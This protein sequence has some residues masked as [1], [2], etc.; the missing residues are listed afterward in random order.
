[1]SGCFSATGS[2]NQCGSQFGQPRLNKADGG[3]GIKAGGIPTRCDDSDKRAIKHQVGAITN[4]SAANRQQANKRPRWVAI[5]ILHCLAPGKLPASRRRFDSAK[6]SLAV[7]GLIVSFS[8]CSHRG[9][10]AS[11]RSVSRAP[12]LQT[13]IIDSRL[14]RPGRLCHGNLETN[15]P[16]IARTGDHTFNTGKRKTPDVHE[17]E[18]AEIAQDHSI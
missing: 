12:S 14:A 10:P 18:V 17:D 8:S 6:R 3:R 7:T 1:M 16:G 13:N 2:G 15:F 11:M 5:P 9:S 4:G